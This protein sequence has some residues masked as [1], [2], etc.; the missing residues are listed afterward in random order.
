MEAQIKQLQS[1]LVN[2]QTRSTELERR[3]A[4]GACSGDN[5]GFDRGDP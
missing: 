4:K 1:A 3:I 2:E 5:H